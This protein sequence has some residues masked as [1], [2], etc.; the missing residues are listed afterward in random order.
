MRRINPKKSFRISGLCMFLAVGIG[1]S[2]AS[3]G[4][5]EE[6]IVQVKDSRPLRA[7]I[8]VVDST[9]NGIVSYEDAVLENKDEFS[10]LP[11]PAAPELAHPTVQGK[12]PAPASFLL[13]PRIGVIDFKFEF[14]DKVS[15]DQKRQILASLIDASERQGNP[16]KFKVIEVEGFLV[17]TPASIRDAKGEWKDAHR[18]LDNKIRIGLGGDQGANMSGLESLESIISAVS[19]VEKK[20]VYIGVAP[21][22]LLAQKYGSFPAGGSEA[23]ARAIIVQTF[24]RLG[25]KP[26]EI[27]WDLRYDANCGCYFFNIRVSASVSAAFIEQ[28]VAG[29]VAKQCEVPHSSGGHNSEE[30]KL[31]GWLDGKDK[32]MALFSGRLFPGSIDF[33]DCWVTEGSIGSG[34][35]TH[36]GCFFMGSGLPEITNNNSITGGIW[37]V[38]AGNVYAKD[39]IGFDLNIDKYY[40]DRGVTIPCSIDFLQHMKIFRDGGWVEYKINKIKEAID[41]DNG[42]VVTRDNASSPRHVPM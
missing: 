2:G 28:S 31:L 32:D 15:I 11:R 9:L 13:V 16:G 38:G 14:Q 10:A 25:F 4:V 20:N 42:T 35:E 34:S 22:N 7:A 5:S 39:H 18:L 23:D 27:G 24:K 41:P 1:L 6:K 33:H 36:D 40:Q 30:S 8:E 3:Y 29:S 12:E 21:Y 37:R 26:G 19:S 17:V